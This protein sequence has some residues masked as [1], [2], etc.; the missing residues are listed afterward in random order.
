MIGDGSALPQSTQA[1]LGWVVREAA[2]NVIHHS[3]ATTCRIELDLGSEATTL[4]VEN[5]GVR[6]DAS[7]GLGVGTGLAGVRERLGEVGGT[8]SVEESPGRFVLVAR[9]PAMS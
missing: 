6:S 3:N 4:R 9:L 1:A 8:L 2:T 7:R 5:D